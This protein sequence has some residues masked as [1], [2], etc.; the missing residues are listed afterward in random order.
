MLRFDVRSSC[1]SCGANSAEALELAAAKAKREH[2]GHTRMRI[3][4]LSVT[5]SAQNVSCRCR[6]IT[7]PCASSSSTAVERRSVRVP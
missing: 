2:D 1:G 3:S 5:H 4:R 6:H 7:L